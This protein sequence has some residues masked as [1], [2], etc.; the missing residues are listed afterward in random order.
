MLHIKHKLRAL[1]TCQKLYLVSGLTNNRYKDILSW[2]K[3]QVQIGKI[4]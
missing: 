4:Y 2:V 1:M 3:P